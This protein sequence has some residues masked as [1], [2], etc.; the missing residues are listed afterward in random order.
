MPSGALSN[1]LRVLDATLAALREGL[2]SGGTWNRSVV[3][4]ATEFGREVAAN[5]NG[6]TDHGSGGAAFVLG[7]AVRGGRVVADWPGL[8]Q[9]DRYEG[10][11]LRITTDLR[12]VFRSVLGEHLRI[13]RAALDASV[14]PGSAKL[15]M[16][17]LLKA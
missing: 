7:G 14:L 17:D 16:L 8:A 11:D 4:V 13:G 2:L 12:A 3:V 15:P 5:G 6:G 9:K 10:R 1:N